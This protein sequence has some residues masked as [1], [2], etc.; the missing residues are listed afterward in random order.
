MS[1]KKKILISLLSVCCV[2]ALLLGFS[3]NSNK[4]TYAATSSNVFLG[5]IFTPTKE[6]A[7]MVAGSFGYENLTDGSTGTTDTERFATKV[8]T[9][10]K[11]DATISLGGVYTLDTLTFNV[12]SD[13]YG[14]V[15]K[16]MGANLLIQTYY[17]GYWTNSIS[18]NRPTCIKRN[19]AILIC[20]KIFHTF[21]D[22]ICIT[23]TIGLCIPSH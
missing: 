14:G 19:A 9:T 17:D 12:F 21:T 23:A 5:K 18:I 4:N 7:G 11:V 13:A 8:A 3:F 2:F 1:I 15:E 6:A 10:S 22:R 16:Y 20:Y